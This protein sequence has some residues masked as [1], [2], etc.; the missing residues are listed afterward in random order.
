[1]T[2]IKNRR[3]F[4]KTT[5]LSLAGLPYITCNLI[6]SP[7]SDKIRVAHVGVNGMGSS[8]IR[9][10]AGFEDTQT[11]ALCDVD[12]HHLAKAKNLLSSLQTGG[13][14]DGYGDY[15]RIMD[16]KDIDVVTCA[17]PDHWHALVAIHAFESG[18]DVYGEKP[19]SYSVKEGQAML[20][21][22]QKHNRIFQ[23]GTQ[24]HAGDNYHRVAEL[25][26]SGILGDIHTVRLWKTG[27]TSGLRY[28]EFQDPPE[29][30]DWNMWLGPAPYSEYTPVRCHKTYRSFFDYSG[31]VFADFWCHIAD[32]MYMSIHP[33]GLSSIDARGEVPTDGIAD[34]PKWI[35]VDYKFEGLDVH[36]TTTPPDVPGAKDM[37]IGAHFE[38][39]KGSLTCDYNTRKIRIGNDVMDDVNEVPKSI[40]RSPGHQRNFLDSVK[41]RNEPESHLAYAREMTLP[42]HLGLI[43][44]RLKRKINWDARSEQIVGDAE[45]NAMLFRPY[46]SPW[47]LPNNG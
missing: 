25:V 17:T 29:H 40:A 15:R 39:T 30:L 26:Q 22:K 28:P 43:S 27:G 9:W 34:T 3:Q 5:G 46:R 41:S 16:R 8:H 21:A 11:V 45:A 42:M 23:L 6:K 24:I 36:W 19:L 13:Q 35:D 20:A 18:K 4:M 2:Y 44:F 10:F 7:P 38:G 32:I 12:D 31:G 33:T 47:E 37:G 1:M 14:V